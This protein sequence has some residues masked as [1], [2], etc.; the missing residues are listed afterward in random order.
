ME[1]PTFFEGIFITTWFFW[2]II[3]F[4]YH[5]RHRSYLEMC[6]ERVEDLTQITDKWAKYEI[7]KK[8]DLER[9]DL[10]KSELHSWSSEE[11]NHE[12]KKEDIVTFFWYV[13]AFFLGGAGLYALVEKIW[14]NL[15]FS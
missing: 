10:I 13:I 11:K 5:G 1:E 12:L 7:N 8:E 15:P 4:H 14:R 9:Y 2:T 6:Y 3:A